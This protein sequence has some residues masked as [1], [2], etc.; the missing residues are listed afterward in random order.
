MFVTIKKYLQVK[1]KLSNLNVKYLAL[2]IEHQALLNKWNTLVQEIND[3]GG[4]EFL[5]K[6]MSGDTLAFSKRDVMFL[7]RLAHPDKNNSSKEANEVT[8]K[9]LA[10][11]AGL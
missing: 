9:L 8:R 6:K 4:R 11:K 5:N 10:I 2:S 1:A 7:L 3:K